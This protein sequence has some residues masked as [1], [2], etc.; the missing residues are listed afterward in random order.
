MKSQSP[1]GCAGT[2]DRPHLGVDNGRVNYEIW[3]GLPHPVLP[4]GHPC[5]VLMDGWFVFARRTVGPGLRPA[6]CGLG[7]RTIIPLRQRSVQ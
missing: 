3:V 7:I 5:I 6:F 1:D 2:M 4:G